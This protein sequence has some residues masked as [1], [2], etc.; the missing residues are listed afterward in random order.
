MLYKNYWLCYNNIS[1]KSVIAILNDGFDPRNQDGDK[2]GSIL[3]AN[4]RELISIENYKIENCREY[5]DENG[6]FMG[7]FPP[8]VIEQGIIDFFEKQ[9]RIHKEFEGKMKQKYLED[10]KK[11]FEDEI[12]FNLYKD[13]TISKETIILTINEF[14]KNAYKEYG[15]VHTPEEYAS[16]FKKYNINLEL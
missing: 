14:N 5:L 6:L 4:T 11:P 3:M 2:D 9:K 10:L 16:I 1:E 8:E 15:I 13:G 12:I 7:M